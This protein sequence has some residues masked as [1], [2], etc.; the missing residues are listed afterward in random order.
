MSLA[1]LNNNYYPSAHMQLPN[2]VGTCIIN[3]N[4]LLSLRC[5]MSGEPAPRHILRSQVTMKPYG[6]V[7][8]WGGAFMI[9]YIAFIYIY[10]YIC[11]D[12]LSIF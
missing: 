4:R 9:T 6:Q 7:R 2:Q 1:A 3:V 10:I 5:G 8:F 12:V 11:R